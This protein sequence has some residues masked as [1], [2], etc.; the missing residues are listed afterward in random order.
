MNGKPDPRVDDAPV[1]VQGT[2]PDETELDPAKTTGPDAP[3]DAR[4]DAG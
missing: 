3:D 1:V 4:G 2:G